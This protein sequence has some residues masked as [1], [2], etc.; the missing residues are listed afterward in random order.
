MKVA[1][2]SPRSIKELESVAST[3]LTQI[4]N[5]KAKK[6]II[7]TPMITDKELA[8]KVEMKPTADI[9]LLQVNFLVPSVKDEY[10][11]QPGAYISRLL[12]SD[13]QGG[14]SDTLIKAG[15]V[16]SVMAGFYAP[17]SDLYSRFS[18]QFKLTNKG[19]DSQDQIM[20]TLFAF[21]ELI[22]KD[23]INETQFNEQKSSLDT[24]FKFLT[25]HS[26][27]N[28]VMGLSANMQ[29]YPVKDILY[30]PY[31][32]DAFNDKFIRQLLTYLTPDNS[33]QFLLAANAK[34]GTEI[35]HYK[36]E[37]AV[38]K[39][40]VKQQ[41]KWLEAAKNIKLVLPTNNIWL[42]ENL[43][44][45]DKEHSGKAIQLINKKGHSV[46][47][48]QSATI[49][50]PK[51]SFKLQLNSELADQS[52][53]N[54]VTMNLFL[55]MLQKQFSE[56]NF[57]TQEAGLSFSVSHANG[58]LISTSGYSDK[59]DKLLLTVVEHI[60]QAQFSEQS[61]LLA[62]EELQRRI[63]NKGK[64]KAM[65]LAF[66]G[67]RQLVRQ[68]A[69]EDK[70]LLA[71]IDK[72][73]LDD[74]TQFKEALFDQS[75]LRL[76]AL[77]NLSQQQ[78]L[79]LDKK[80][81]QEITVKATDFYSI[82]RLN[83]DLKQGALNYS[84]QSEMQDDALVMVHLTDL[85]GDTA[86][87]TSELLNK[88]LQPAFYDQ[89]RTQEQLSYSPFTASFNV[90]EQV[91]FG[92]FTQSPAASN[93]ELYGR[94]NQFLADFKGKL[95]T[96]TEEKFAKIKAAHVANYLAKPTSLSGEFSY[97][98]NEWLMMKAQ[99]NHKQAYIEALQAVSLQQVKHFY[100]DVLATNKN[101]QLI[102]V[103]VQGQKFIKS[104][105]L[106][107]EKQ[108]TIHNIDKLEK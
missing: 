43:E 11:Y 100:E 94:F 1:L 29:L 83:A 8:I 31:R 90:N 32:L 62:K 13:H 75:A 16:D 12:G 42:P 52:A 93:S 51:A 63:N 92:L 14:L 27:F 70:T 97:L 20:T 106:S 77:G 5:K 105:V 59:Q 33:R 39:V 85:K 101:S 96:T 4:P 22:K 72:L 61:L 3:Y 108:L 79:A 104:P 17:H 30:F 47:F 107:V 46:W 91:A 86:L 68:P 49:E 19:I 103:Q 74:I 80:L 81:T 57:V 9:K 65:D 58:L 2:T 25:K 44:I 21:I 38:E 45:V 89:I 55:S 66:G 99:I 48:A 69:W 10:M 95:A 6:A 41:Q 88:L 78:V 28:Y 54:R 23:G 26:G 36:G 40:T 98:S 60:K 18:L 53:K 50:E 102:L 64:M 37:Y 87:A 34:G 73:S 56:L 84:L 82:K 15:L 35:P 71:A 76:L 24:R 67:F 7:L